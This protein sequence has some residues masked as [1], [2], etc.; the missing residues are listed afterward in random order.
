MISVYLLLDLFINQF[1][2]YQSVIGISICSV[3]DTSRVS[4]M[5]EQKT[6]HADARRVAHRTPQNSYPTTSQ[7]SLKDYILPFRDSCVLG[8]VSKSLPYSQ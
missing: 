5:N 6:T 8:E 7:K 2:V 4:I 1:L 3:S